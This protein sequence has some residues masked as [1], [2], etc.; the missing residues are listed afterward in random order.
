[1]TAKA[2]LASKLEDLESTIKA[3][4]QDGV[5]AVMDAKASAKYG[6]DA[7]DYIVVGGGPGGI[8]VAT[9]LSADRSTRVLL[10]EAG[11]DRDA[12]PDITDSAFAWARAYAEKRGGEGQSVV[13]SAHA[14]GW[15]VGPPP[16]P[17]PPPFFP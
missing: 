17:P 10:L 13:A 7:Y 5:D 4:L 11:E 3:G 12:D 9:A 1:V 14:S 8:S 16:P 15:G 6:E 2:A